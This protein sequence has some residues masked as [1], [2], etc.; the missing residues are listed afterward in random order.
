MMYNSQYERDFAKRLIQVGL[1]SLE[2]FVNYFRWQ[3][4]SRKTLL[5][6]TERVLD[7]Q[8]RIF[9]SVSPPASKVANSV[10]AMKQESN[11]RS[12]VSK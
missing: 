8:T 5:V 11:H 9:I 10:D 1:S 7:N 6:F 2:T 3:S 4:D 12:R